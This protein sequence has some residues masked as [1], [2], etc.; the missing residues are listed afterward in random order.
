MPD[1]EKYNKADPLADAGT[2]E[3]EIQSAVESRT[4]DL[5][6]M[7]G[8]ELIK[9]ERLA[10]EPE[11]AAADDRVKPRSLWQDAWRDLRRNPI[12]IISGLLI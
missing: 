1:E 6:T 9:N 5:G 11:I 4:F 8:Q 12:F 3:E 10:D 7:E 2:E